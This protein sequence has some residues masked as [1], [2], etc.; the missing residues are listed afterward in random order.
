MK[1]LTEGGVIPL[2]KKINKISK[3]IARRWI[4]K[5]SAQ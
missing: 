1:K 4:S 5:S 2:R 3:E